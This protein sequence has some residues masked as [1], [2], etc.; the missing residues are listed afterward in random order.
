MLAWVEV[1]YSDIF[2]NIPYIV[3]WPLRL[4]LWYVWSIP[5]CNWNISTHFLYPAPGICLEYAWHILSESSQV[6]VYVWNI[7]DMIFHAYHDS[8]L[9]ISSTANG[10]WQLYTKLPLNDSMVVPMPWVLSSGLSETLP[11]AHHDDRA[12][13]QPVFHVLPCDGPSAAASECSSMLPSNSS[14]ASGWQSA[15]CLI[16]L[17]CVLSAL[18][19]V[20]AISLIK[21]YH[22]HLVICLE[23]TTWI[24]PLLA[25]RPAAAMQ[26]GCSC[27]HSTCILGVKGV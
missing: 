24:I 3:L 16:S 11:V 13:C 5:T 20:S 19:S 15:P 10:C 26:L 8:F 22:H 2:L 25:N 4:G 12:V 21:F 14:V 27:C 7:P 17:W 1:G 23:Y 18:C 6:Q 9:V